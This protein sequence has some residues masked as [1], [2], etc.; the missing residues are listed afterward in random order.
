MEQDKRV[1]VMEVQIIDLDHTDEF[2]NDLTIQEMEEVTFGM[3]N[4][5]ATGFDIIPAET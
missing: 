2:Y 3:E 5:E 4:N 1:L